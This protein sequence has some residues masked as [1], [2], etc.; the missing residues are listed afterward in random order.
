M[1]GLYTLSVWGRKPEHQLTFLE[2]MNKLQEAFE[3]GFDSARITR[4]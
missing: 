2:A 3:S 1:P 4:T